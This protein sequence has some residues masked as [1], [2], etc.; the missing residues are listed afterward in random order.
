MHIALY[1]LNYVNLV[2]VH[3][4]YIMQYARCNEHIVKCTM[5]N[6]VFNMYNE[7]AFAYYKLF[8]AYYIL[9]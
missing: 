5:Q 6:A 8:T 9:Q 2:P 1:I 3:A 7:I 4:A